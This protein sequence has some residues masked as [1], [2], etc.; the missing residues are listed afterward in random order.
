[1]RA[2]VSCD[3]T[4]LDIID[5]FRGQ[6]T[7]AILNLTEEN[8][9]LVSLLPHNTISEHQPMYSPVNKTAKDYFKHC[10]EEWHANEIMQQLEENEDQ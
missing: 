7:K 5:N 4:A 8:N 9:I 6:T 2:D 3:K 1:M 10:F